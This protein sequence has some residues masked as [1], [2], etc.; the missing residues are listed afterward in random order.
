[1]LASG[2]CTWLLL[3]LLDSR[4]RPSSRLAASN[5]R[6]GYAS[7]AIWRPVIVQKVVHFRVARRPLSL[8]ILSR[9][10]LL[11]LFGLLLILLLLLLELLAAH[12][13][14]VA[15]IWGHLGPL[16]L[17]LRLRLSQRLRVG[18][19]GAP[20][21]PAQSPQT[22][23]GDSRTALAGRSTCCRVAARREASARRH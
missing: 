5:V 15:A 20:L 22:V 6:R 3:L 11:V 8:L 19:H 17:R 14:G 16:P 13:V 21:R 1:M 4:L 18:V 12:E 2:V 23:P 7:V 9:L 10:W